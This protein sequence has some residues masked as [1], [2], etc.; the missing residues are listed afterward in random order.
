MCHENFSS[1]TEYPITCFP[2][3]LIA[4]FI[5][6]VSE[7]ILIVFW[8]PRTVPSW[9]QVRVLSASTLFQIIFCGLLFCAG[10]RS[11]YIFLNRTNKCMNLRQVRQEMCM[12]QPEKQP[13]GRPT[14]RWNNNV[15]CMLWKQD[16][17]DKDGTGSEYSVAGSISGN[18]P[19]R[20]LTYKVYQNLLP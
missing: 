17:K 20:F 10:E 13:L 18:E 6:P 8:H 19:L 11:S 15:Q 5:R 4:V 16:V 3:L 7:A 1:Y 9:L 12:E 2:V 14:K